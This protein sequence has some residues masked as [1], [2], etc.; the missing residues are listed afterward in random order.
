[1]GTHLSPPSRIFSTSLNNIAPYS[2]PHSLL[3]CPPEPHAGYS[4]RTGGPV[5]EEG[6]SRTWVTIR[7]LSPAERERDAVSTAEEFSEWARADQP[8]TARWVPVPLANVSGTVAGPGALGGDSAEKPREAGG[9]GR[10]EQGGRFPQGEKHTQPRPLQL[11]FR[12]QR[13]AGPR[14][15]EK[16]LSGPPGGVF[17]TSLE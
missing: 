16:S 17:C 9:P 10:A 11:I 14:D 4:M 8:D 2:S 13:A 12:T 7:G 6:G 5:T 15:P 1:M 3:V